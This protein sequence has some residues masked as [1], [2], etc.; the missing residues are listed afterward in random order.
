M[1]VVILFGGA[2]WGAY[3]IY[4]PFILSMTVAMLLSMATM[5]LM[6]G[7]TEILRY[8]KLA[9]FVMV[10]LLVLLILAPIFYIA[11]SG[12]EYLGNLDQKKLEE[13]FARINHLAGEIPYVGDTVSEYLKADKLLHYFKEISA[14]ATT[15]GSKGLS[16]L[17]NILFVIAFY[18]AIVYYQ[19]KF[20]SLISSLIPAPERE[21]REIMSEITSTMEV[22]FYSIIVTAL[23]EG[24]L[25][26]VFLSYYGFDG[27]FFG[28]IYGF[29]SLVPVVGGA[30]VW[31]PVSIY[32]WSEIDSNTAIVIAIYSIVIISIF[33]DT[34]VKPVII[35]TIK[36][37]MLEN[38]TSLN[39]LVIFFSIIAGMSTYGFWGMILGPAITTFLFA[40]GRIYLQYSRFIKMGFDE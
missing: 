1:F 18:A 21:S 9:T 36:E 24:F 10:L 38:S 19:D 31:L 35:K 39:E 40:A 22:V 16:F 13:I 8:R 33:A 4:S 20:F 25:F 26:G 5:N 14:Y 29:S 2:L 15:M 3:T 12:V 17:K 27:L 7:L 6:V 28:L 30:L 34:F 23:F 32:A 37:E 11:T